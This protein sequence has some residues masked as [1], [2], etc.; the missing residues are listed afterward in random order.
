MEDFS[1]SLKNLQLK[2]TPRRLAIL[3]ILASESVYLSPEEVWQK[4]KTRFAKTGLPSVYRN[5]EALAQGGVIIQ[6]IH[7]DRKL[8]YYHCRNGSHHHH[9]V[10]IAC[11]KV[12]DLA[13]CG[14]DEIEQEIKGAL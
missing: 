1:A 5:L 2:A 12:Q 11:R 6:I 10:C 9:F 8:Y 14:M 4:L 13:F 3:D 7:P